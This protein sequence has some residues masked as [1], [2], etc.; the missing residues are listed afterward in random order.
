MMDVLMPVLRWWLALAV[1]GW[2]AMPIA[3]RLFRTLPD[4]GMAFARPLG[5][6]LAGYVYWLGVTAGLLPNTWAGVAFAVVAVAAL[7]GWLAWRDRQALGEL[8][9]ERRVL[10][11]GYECLFALA[12]AAWALYKAH[13]PAIET[14]GGEKYMEMAFIDAILASPRFPP[15]D[16]WMSGLAISYYYFGYVIAAM[17]IR[18][19]G[20]LSYVGFNL[21]VPSVFG[22]SLVGLYGIGNDLVELGG[23]RARWPRLLTGG[24]T[25]S[26]V[27]IVGNLEGALEVAYLKGVGSSAFWNW[28]DVR[29]LTVGPGTCNEPGEGFGSGAW[30]PTRHIWWWRASRVIQ[31]N[32]GEVI[33]EFPFFSFMLADNHPHLLAL[34]FAI[35]ALG[36]ALAVLTG[37]LEGE[38]DRPYWS[39]LWLALPFAV[40][41][42][43]FL[44][45]WDLPTYAFVVVAAFGLRSLVREPSIE[46][47]TIADGLLL[48][49]AAAGL[50]AIGWRLAARLAAGSSEVGA[51]PSPWP[52]LLA[53]ALSVTVAAALGYWLYQRASSGDPACRRALSVARF[54]IW[55]LVI[56]LVFY[57]PFHIGFQSQVSGIGVVSVRS[58]LPQW[59]VHFGFL[60]FLAL[61]L[62][63]VHV[64]V[65]WR[66][67]R[68]LGWG[69][70]LVLA[71]LLPVAGLS[72]GWRAWVALVLALSLAAAAI[73]GIE[74]WADVAADGGPPAPAATAR[75]A[76]A[77]SL[78]RLSVDW[79][80]P[81]TF[82]L[83]CTSVGLLLALGTEFVFIRDLF[84]SRMN[85][86]FKLFFQAWVLLAVGGGYAAFATWRRLG[87][88]LFTA[89]AV[90]AAILLVASLAYPAAAVYSRTGGL[91]MSDLSL[92]GLKWWESSYPDDL[93]AVTW[94]RSNA[95]DTPTILEAPGGGYEHNGRIS[96]ATGFPTVLG[97]EG[98]E[99]QWRGTYAEID[100]RK[101]DAEA[102]YTTHNERQFRDLLAKYHIR[103]VIV[104][105]VERAKYGLTAADEKRLASWLTPV[106]ESGRTRILANPTAD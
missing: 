36:L 106:F 11:I 30:I 71:V 94:L 48:G 35:M 73:A 72:L 5:L 28:L 79:R 85:T 25:A 93:A 15:S 96:M 77:R 32:C 14:A 95:S 42:L 40:G 20:V 91:R 13:N 12:F 1:V 92:N 18:L 54:A 66:H 82:A 57:L 46:R 63:A 98:H 64:N 10:V 23:V 58:R 99:H 83:L 81:A 47:W 43:G 67:R 75:P 78:H 6:L 33:H 8:V 17:L 89:W 88:W 90:P 34:P 52:S 44:N 105:D 38:G 101:A 103:Y 87:R 100:P 4:R 3:R 102:M 97:W 7:G 84:G 31:D 24:L 86:V 41:A 51:S 26:L 104:G 69:S 50:G 9:R 60:L 21:V 39:A 80:L 53:A 68:S 76:Q 22:M 45:A 65:A 49:V 62:V 16:P 55:L 56:S 37:L 29:N 27:G 70:Y 19:T 61:T 2:S 74:L 59:L